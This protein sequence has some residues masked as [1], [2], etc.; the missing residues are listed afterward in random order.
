MTLMTNQRF[1]GL[2]GQSR[3]PAHGLP[4][5]MPLVIAIH[6]GT[7]TSNYFNVPGYSLLDRAQAN[8]I[9]IIAIDR[10]GYVESPLLPVEQSSIHGQA[11]VLGEIWKSHGAG[12]R[13]IVLI[14]HSIG[15]AIAARIAS[16][17][18]N[19]PLLGLAMSGI[20]LRTP[21]EHKPMWEALPD[22]P[23]VEL[24]NELKDQV[25]FGP[26][27]SFD[28]NV[29]P[30]ASYIANAPGLRAELVDIVS[31]WQDDVHDVLG[32]IA[33]PV[34][35]RQAEN[36]RLW[37][38]DQGEVDGFARALKSSPRVDAAML[39]GTGHCIDFHYLGP[40]F[41]LQQLGFALEC[42]NA[43]A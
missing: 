10:P 42:A 15:A 2:S 41:Q 40:A 1:G 20:G 12:T 16:E 36:D 13:G 29:M 35:Y 43:A 9:P 28:G 4:P 25:M 22:I 7:Y 34:H 6:G 24:P 5:R 11:R 38:V 17:P 14:A 33:V 21:P 37:I 32:R 27:A 30:A 26:E 31:T 3:I 39:H 19:L 18:G 23:R 8:G